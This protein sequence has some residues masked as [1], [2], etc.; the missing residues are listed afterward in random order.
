MPAWIA[1][2]VFPI[3]LPGFPGLMSAEPLCPMIS[4]S[5]IRF[6]AWI[7]NAAWNPARG[8]LAAYGILKRTNAK[9]ARAI[10]G[11]AMA[12]S[13]RNHFFRMSLGR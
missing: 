7:P 12:Q 13:Q 10:V 9:I 2:S 6:P 11:I 1:F 5:T 3:G 4:A 8:A